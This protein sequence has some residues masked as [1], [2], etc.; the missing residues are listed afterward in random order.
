M[1]GAR[2]D[3]SDES[4]AAVPW[5][6][7]ALPLLLCSRGPGAS[8][9]DHPLDRVRMQKAVFL[10]IQR[11]PATWR[12]YYA[13]APYNWGPYCRDLNDD[14]RRLVDARLVRLSTADGSRYG[15]FELTSDGE[16]VAAELRRHLPPAEREF[17]TTVRAYV[18]SRNFNDL[19]REV[20]AAYPD[21]ASKSKWS[22]RR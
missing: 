16:E 6:R 21:Y 11:G 5:Q 8:D 19:L 13:Y 22:G 14:L 3:R 15:R 20:Y 7:W 9:G 1:T 2:A 4:A 17:V 18:T 10:L 12:S